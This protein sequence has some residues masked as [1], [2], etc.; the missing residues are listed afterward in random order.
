MDKTPRSTP[1]DRLKAAA[2]KLNKRKGSTPPTS[3]LPMPAE[4]EQE[5]DGVP[6]KRRFPRLLARRSTLPAKIQLAMGILIV[7]GVAGSAMIVTD[8]WR[9]LVPGMSPQKDQPLDSSTTAVMPSLEE[10]EDMFDPSEQGEA[11]ARNALRLYSEGEMPSLGLFSTQRFRDVTGRSPEEVS[12]DTGPAPVSEIRVD[13][14]APEVDGV[15][16]AT[17]QFQVSTQSRRQA[18]RELGGFG[19]EEFRPAALEGALLLSD[20]IEAQQRFAAMSEEE[21]EERQQQFRESSAFMEIV[22]S[23]GQ[24]VGRHWEPPRERL[25]ADG[26][27]IE[28]HLD[29]LGGITSTDIE[30]STGREPY[31]RAVL[32]A[33]MASGPFSEVTNLPP[34]IWP[35]METVRLSF[36]TPP[37]SPDE[38]AQRRQDG[39]LREA[40]DDRDGMSVD[41]V[42][43]LLGGDSNQTD[44]YDTIRQQVQAEFRTLANGR[45]TPSRDAEIRVQISLPLG[46]VLD[47]RVVRTSGDHEMDMVALQA[48]D[49]SGPFRGVRHLQPTEQR[50]LEYFTL[51]FHENGVR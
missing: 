16:T 43:E 4:Q 19:R 32:D 6:S 46:V 36:G 1:L 30:R 24:R 8:D 18:I 28:V 14:D 20:A 27:V 41:E 12:D 42:R 21:I 34:W 38:H 50:R 3:D 45:Y 7:G 26:A 47:S 11:A 37:I 44:Y 49:A 35:V 5:L 39:L 22:R 17:P 40:R 29:R 2:S 23:I 13:R 25:I 9:S 51:H 31:D 33:V 48:I 10:L 15:A